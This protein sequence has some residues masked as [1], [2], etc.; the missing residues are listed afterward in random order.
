MIRAREQIAQSFPEEARKLLDRLPP[1]LQNSAP[2]LKLRALAGA[3]P[4]AHASKPKRRRQRGRPASKDSKPKPPVT[5]VE[6]VLFERVDG[7]GFGG[8][9]VFRCKGGGRSTD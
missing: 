4:P 9:P 5:E 8:L 1:L 3:L 6:G 2:V 7:A